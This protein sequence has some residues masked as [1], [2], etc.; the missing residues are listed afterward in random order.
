MGVLFCLGAIIWNVTRPIQGMQESSAEAAPLVGFI[1]LP[2]DSAWRQSFNRSI[3]KAAAAQGMQLLTLNAR[4][5]QESEKSAFRALVAYDVDAIIFTPVIATGWDDVLEEARRSEIP[6]ILAGEM[7]ET[8][9]QDAVYA[10]VGPDYRRLGLSAAAWI[11]G[12]F[13][14]DRHWE[15]VEFSGIVGSSSSANISG[16]LRQGLRGT[17]AFSI[18]YTVSAKDMFTKSRQL[19]ASYLKSSHDLSDHII[20]LGYSDA[21]T[22]GA[23]EAMEEKGFRPGKDIHILSFGDEES[24]FTAVKEGMISCVI[25]ITSATG[26]EIVATVSQA[27]QSDSSEESK[28]KK[29]YINEDIQM[30]E[31]EDILYE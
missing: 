11:S 9:I 16:G 24:T 30:Y 29:I 6:V 25:T 4:K 26:E 21:M 15:I 7:L 13:N 28:Y 2:E 17:D 10:Y 20:F 22:Q 31:K 14:T 23:I 1:S 18:L 27:V 12:H 8:D 5:T 19:L 3:E